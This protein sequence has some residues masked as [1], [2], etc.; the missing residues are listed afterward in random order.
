MQLRELQITNNNQGFT[1]IELV[2]VILVLGIL[3]V[4]AAP[5][6]IDL[7]GDAEASSVLSLRGALKDGSQFV[8]LKAIIENI[9][10]GNNTITLNGGNISIRA[11][12]PRV[13]NS[14]ANFTNQMQYW[15]ELDLDD[16][17]C[18]GGNDADWYGVVDLNAFH[19]MPANYNSTDQN[20]YVTYTTAS[21]FIAGSGWVDKE[22][23]E[24]TSTTT[25]CN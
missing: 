3:T 10:S 12:F 2:V 8:H 16:T 1:L 11:G 13:A 6:F 15:L 24:I 5:K 21:E 14:C 9:D 17:I 23:A 7:K 19:L 4:V 20:C 18:S 22:F 25:G